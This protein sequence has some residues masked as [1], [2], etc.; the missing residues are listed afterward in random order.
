MLLYNI[1]QYANVPFFSVF[2]SYKPDAQY[3]K[4]AWVTLEESKDNSVSVEFDNEYRLL[5]IDCCF[6]PN[7]TDFYKLWQHCSGDLFMVY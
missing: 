3:L 6:Y 4:G 7:I 5:T 1:T 2:N